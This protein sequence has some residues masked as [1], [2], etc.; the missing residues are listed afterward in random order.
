MRRPL[1][2]LREDD[3]RRDRLRDRRD[4][5]GGEVSGEGRGRR[6]VKVG[7]RNHHVEE[8]HL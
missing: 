1:A 8:I 6:D 4:G 5:G 3:L 7:R 2:S